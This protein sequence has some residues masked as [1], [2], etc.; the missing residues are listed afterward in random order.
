[1]A[2]GVLVGAVWGGAIG[3]IISAIRGGS[4]GKALKMV[5]FIHKIPDLLKQ[6]ILRKVENWHEQATVG[7]VLLMKKVPKELYSLNWGLPNE[8]Y[9]IEKE[10]D[11]WQVYYRERGIKTSIGYFENDGYTLGLP[12]H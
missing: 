9:C 7:K 4:F 11:R 3:G 8:T 10:N 1:M 6:G 12:T 2:K 5:H